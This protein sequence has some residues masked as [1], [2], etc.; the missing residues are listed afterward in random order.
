[1]KKFETIK[2]DKKNKKPQDSV[3]LPQPP[4]NSAHPSKKDYKRKP[5]HKKPLV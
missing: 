4:P 2:K 5:K 1:M 3:R